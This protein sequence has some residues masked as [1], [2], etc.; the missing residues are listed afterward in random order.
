MKII[1]KTGMRIRNL[2]IK[3]KKKETNI[4]TENIKIN[5]WTNWKTNTK[6]ELKKTIIAYEYYWNNT[7]LNKLRIKCTILF[8]NN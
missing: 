4:K 1:A 5:L 3:Q 6:Y 2:E 8:R 7:K